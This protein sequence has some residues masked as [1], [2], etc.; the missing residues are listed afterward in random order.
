MTVEN[1]S[2]ADQKKNKLFAYY[3][4]T[5]LML[6]LQGIQFQTLKYVRN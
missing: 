2:N 4:L 5:T 3:C 1:T 6:K